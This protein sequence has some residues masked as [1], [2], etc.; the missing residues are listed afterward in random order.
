MKRATGLAGITFGLLAFANAAMADASGTWNGTMST[1]N[2]DIPVSFSFMEDGATLTG[3]TAGPDGTTTPI[4]DGKVDGDNVSFVVN[5]DFNGMPFTM[6][7]TGIVKGDSLDFTVDI[8][9]MPVMLTV[10]RAAP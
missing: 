10:S 6:S 7:Y 9:G 1:P 4:S 5:L 2:G 3:S 8:F